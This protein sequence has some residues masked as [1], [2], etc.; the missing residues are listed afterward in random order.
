MT[1]KESQDDLFKFLMIFILLFF[2]FGVGF[3][4]FSYFKERKDYPIMICQQGKCLRAKKVEYT[5]RCVRT[6]RGEIICGNYVL[7]IE[8]EAEISTKDKK[9]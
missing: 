7:M 3:M 9:Q 2:I 6:E 8:R 4:I 5:E 1:I